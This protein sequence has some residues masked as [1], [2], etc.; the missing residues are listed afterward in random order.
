MIGLKFSV[1]AITESGQADMYLLVCDDGHSFLLGELHE[2]CAIRDAMTDLIA[3]GTHAG[4]I[5]ADDPRYAEWLTVAQSAELSGYARQTVRAACAKEKI[6]GAIRGPWRCTH[7]ALMR[8]TQDKKA[9][10]RGRPF[11]E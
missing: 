2:V 9:H 10:K 4:E 7:A 8:W 3:R 5:E 11:K 1:R 6:K